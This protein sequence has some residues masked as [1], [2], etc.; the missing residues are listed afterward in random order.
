MAEQ[1]EV[2]II[3]ASAVQNLA[4]LKD[5]IKKAKE[6]LDGMTIGGEKYQ[7]Q[8]DEL[9]K[10]QN[11]MRNA[12]YATTG[13]MDSLKK[14]SEGVGTSYNALVKRMADLKREFRATEDAAKRMELGKQITELNDALKQLDATQGVFSRNVGMYADT[15]KHFPPT[16]G[17]IRKEM[18]DIGETLKIMGKQPILGMLGLLAP[19]IIKIADG[20]KD[21]EKAMAGIK[22]LMDA[23]KPVTDVFAGLLDKIADILMDVINEVTAFLGSSGLLQSVIKGVMG[24]G[25]AIL[26]FVVAPFKGVVEAI[27]VFREKGVKGLGDAA[28]AFGNEMKNG[29]SFKENFTAG[30]AV[31]DTMLTGMASRKKK[32]QET[33]KTIVTEVANG[34]E[35]SIDEMIKK[36]FDRAEKAA[37]ERLAKRRE[38]ESVVDDLIAQNLDEINAEMEA[39]FEAERIMEETS[40]KMAEEA[41]KKKIAA[42]EAY[43]SGTSDLLSALADAYESNGELSEKEEQRVKNLRIAAATID[44]LQGVVTA[45]S[46]AHELGPVAGP[47]VGAINAA[48]IVAT[49]VANINKIRSTS[50][51][52]STAPSSESA[53]VPAAVSAP[54]VETAVPTTTVVNGASTTAALN[55]AAQPQ[56]VYVVQ[57]DIE[58]VGTRVAVT[59]GESSF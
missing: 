32:A 41:A 10:M 59:E 11:L 30:Q 16:F 4:D 50:V 21:N 1:V 54:N 18:G 48:A 38:D 40:V 42:M 58:A 47:I 34:A 57:S 29:V 31:A 52:G 26:K 23:L 12:M 53:S 3:T 45:F 33:G 39:Y 49:G 14:A 25:N 43:A 6:G 27:K 15:L 7:E 24:V 36:A 17:K 55:A 2:P 13:D 5:A 8:L 44:M 20:L 46:T 28:K 37:A 9:I 19:I 35:E 22:K 51:S 56:R